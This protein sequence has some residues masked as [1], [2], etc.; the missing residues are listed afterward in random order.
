VPW[1]PAD[2]PGL[3]SWHEA[4]DPLTIFV[5]ASQ[6]VTEWRDKSGAGR[7][8]T[9]GTTAH[10]ATFDS[11]KKALTRTTQG[12]MMLMAND[13]ANQPTAITSAYLVDVLAGYETSSNVVMAKGDQPWDSPGFYVTDNASLLQWRGTTDATGMDGTNMHWIEVNPWPSKP[14]LSVQRWGAAGGTAFSNGVQAGPRATSA[15]SFIPRSNTAPRGILRWARTLPGGSDFFG[16]FYCIIESSQAVSDADRE[17]LEGYIAHGAGK[18]SL[19]P[20][21]HPYKSAPPTK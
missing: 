19:L 20:A 18:A 10:M 12:G 1:T 7:H 13:T 14:Q 2:L 21:N 3:Y 5:D 15:L 11:G 16:D 9:Q 8:Y 17:R 4:W 6:R